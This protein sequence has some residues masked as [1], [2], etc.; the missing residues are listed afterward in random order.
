MPSR[1]RLWLIFDGAGTGTEPGPAS[2]VALVDGTGLAVVTCMTW[3]LVLPLATTLLANVPGAA[4][5][6]TIEPVGVEPSTAPFP[7]EPPEPAS[8]WYGAP[9]LVADVA[10]AAGI[11]IVVSMTDNDHTRS[12]T[13]AAVYALGAAYLVAGPVVHL[14]HRH[15][16]RSVESLLLRVGGLAA[17]LALTYS[18][19]DVSGCGAEVSEHVPCR[20]PYALALAPLTAMLFDDVLLSHEPAAQP[21][22]ASAVSP[23]V[24]VQP[25]VALLGV[26]GTF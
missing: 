5:Q 21:Q 15:A 24:L 11:S 18:L 20:A 10:A 1:E 23:R 2:G 16:L 13:P 6:L 26:G 7:G 4:P 12:G 22:H 17:G 8:D 3:F 14:A 9:S 25:G 19:A